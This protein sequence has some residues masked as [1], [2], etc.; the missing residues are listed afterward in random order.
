LRKE[1][2]REKEICKED[3]AIMRK[4]PETRAFKGD[5]IRMATIR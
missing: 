1:S 4:D 2:E 3:V 5:D